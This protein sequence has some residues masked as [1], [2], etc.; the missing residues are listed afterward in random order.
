MCNCCFVVVY[1]MELVSQAKRGF[2]H[3]VIANRCLSWG[4]RG[5]YGV[6]V[7]L[8]NG[9]EDSPRIYDLRFSNLKDLEDMITKL[10][11]LRDKFTND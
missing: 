9:L 11:N 6:G 5:V 10:E 2:N 7:K 8:L 4:G 3:K 1:L